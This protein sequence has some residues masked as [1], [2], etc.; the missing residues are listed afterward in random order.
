MQPRKP[1]IALNSE[2]YIALRQQELR[3]CK[4]IGYEFYCKELFVV[5]HK[6]SYSCE[7]AIYFNL[8]TDIIKENCDFK[9]YYNNTDI[10]PT[11]F[12]GGDKIILANWSNDKHTICNTNN[13]ILVKI[14]SHLYVLV[15]RS[16][17]CNCSIEAYTLYLLESLAA[18]DNKISKLIMYFTINTAFTNYVEMFPNLTDS[19]QTP[20]IKNRTTYEQT[21]P[22]TLNV[23][24]FDRSLLHPSMDLKDFMDHYTKRK[25]IFDLQERHDSTFNTN[26]NFFSNN[27][28][29][30]IFVFISSI[31]SLMSTTLI[32]YLICKH[33]QIRMLVASL[34]LH[35]IKEVSVNSRETNPAECTALAYIGIILTILNLIL[36][37]Y[38]HFRKSRLCKGHRFSNAVKIMI[39]ISDV[40]NYV[41]IK[42]C[43]ATG[44]I[45]LFKIIGMLKAKN[46]KLNKKL[47]MGHF[48]GKLEGS[49]SDF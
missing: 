26:K 36:V 29:L 12:N 18:C 22:I 15:N 24:K 40:Q 38:L 20:L 44:I 7:S 47:L 31:I 32:I 6:T 30:D 14:P 8:D 27:H 13:D 23:S 37:T 49:H 41:P 4:R 35:Q 33:K 16:V 48:G 25:E 17:L 9:F 11:V 10:I 3:T 21:L 5:K 28:I 2:T 42:F 43:K 39:F 1:Y 45:H 46:I 19:L 34:P